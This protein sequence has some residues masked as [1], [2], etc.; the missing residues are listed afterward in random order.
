MT[1]RDRRTT[2]SRK[3]RRVAAWMGA[4]AA[5]VAGVVLGATFAGGSSDAPAVRSVA[6]TAPVTTTAAPSATAVVLPAAATATV[7]GAATAQ[8][9]LAALPVKGR[10]PMTGYDRAAFGQ[11]WADVDR[12]GCDTRN[13]VL[14]RDVTAAVV[15]PDTHGCVVLSGSVDAPYSGTTL[16]FTRG[17]DTSADVQIDHVVAL[18]DAWQTGA[19]QW[20]ATTRERF[21]NDPANL[22]A[23]DGT[24]NQQKG[25]G[26]A[27]TWLPPNK[28][29]RCT[30]VTMQV[31]VK[32][33]YGLW[34]TAPERDAIGR[35]LATCPGATTPP[36]PTVTA[37]ST[38]AAPP[39][40]PAPVVL[41]SAPPAPPPTTDPGDVHYANCD[42]VRAAGKAPL[43]AGQPGYSRKLDRDG[44][45][46]ACE[47]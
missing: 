25:A 28:A 41:T 23:V 2:R 7:P 45:G 13:D 16:P 29:F 5:A 18:G 3:R 46:V 10:A 26:D 22:L 33:D 31:A 35:V 20:T 15:D 38:S 1:A 42:A 17:A 6:G 4:G 8:A 12:N 30:Y 36:T 40:P 19:Q 21:A 43:L 32:R 34:V 11:A 39:A 24:L 27:A 9:E 14:R 47:T 37:P 44:D